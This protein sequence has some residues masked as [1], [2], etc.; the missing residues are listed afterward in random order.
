MEWLDK[1]NSFNSYK[2]LMYK[3]W[4]DAIL[5]GQFLPPIECSVDPVNVCNLDCIYCNNK[6]T[7]ARG[8]MMTRE[9]LLDLFSFFKSWGAKAI[10]IAGGGEPTL[11]PN[12]AEA[13]SLA[14]NLNMPI[15]MLTNGSFSGSEDLLMTCAKCMRWIGISVDSATAETY[16]KLK[17]KDLFEFV[18][19][20]IKQLVES[21]AR[22]VTYK[23]LL[24]PYNQH[25]VYKAIELAR[26]LGCHR[27]HI[28]PVSFLNFQD[29][30]EKYDIEGITEQVAK[31]RGM[32]ET[33]RFRI[34]YVQH[35]YDKDLHR[36]FG[37][38]KCNVTPLMPIFH[39]QG[40]ISICIDRKNDASMVIGSHEPVDNILKVWGSEHHK[41]VIDNVKLSECPKCTIAPYQCQY[42]QCI[43]KNSMDWEFV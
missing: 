33:D 18:L 36:K 11:H 37:F 25:E 4:Y 5:A 15:A 32:F 17:G 7:K 40:D 29:H 42:E 9:H 27:I 6:L 35:K 22:E 23:F 2:G 41:K 38:K 8:V 21:G 20:N 26:D 14:Y 13:V 30:E 1:Y 31:A 12:L 28:R 43:E 19:S 3:Q 24:H 34:F 10:C 39:S 16:V